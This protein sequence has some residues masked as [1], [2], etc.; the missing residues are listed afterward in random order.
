MI[1]T[2]VP[3]IC[4]IVPFTHIMNTPVLDYDF[5]LLIIY[6]YFPNKHLFQSLFF[7]KYLLFLKKGMKGWKKSQECEK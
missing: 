6:L 5:G 1:F 2:F 7:K 4:T 3:Y